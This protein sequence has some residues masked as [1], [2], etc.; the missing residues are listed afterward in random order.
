MEALITKTSNLRILDNSEEK[1]LVRLSLEGDDRAQYRLYQKYVKAMYHTIVRMVGDSLDAE[2]LTQELFV[3]VFK[4]LDSYKGKAT[5]GAWIKRIAINTALNFIRSRG[6]IRMVE[7]VEEYDPSIQS[8]MDFDASNFD[9]KK[10][11]QAIKELPEG[12]RMVFN[13]FMMEGYQHREIA[14]ILGISE[15]TSKTQFRRAK[16]L[17][18]DI[19][20]KN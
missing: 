16:Q 19:L 1:E 20:I 5:L 7:M 8:E 3:K 17:L 10:V 18:R 6:N 15:S 2:D 4:N 12:C 13:L 9:I 14:Q 11:H